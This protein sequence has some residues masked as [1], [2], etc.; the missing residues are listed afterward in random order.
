MESNIL[1]NQYDIY[2]H[3]VSTPGAAVSLQTCVFL[4]NLCNKLQPKTL[5]DTGSGFSSYVF[6][7]WAQPNNATVYSIDDN[8]DW[9]ARSK[10]FCEEQNVYTDNFLLFKDIVIIQKQTAD[11]VLHDLGNRE[12]RKQSLGIIYDLCKRGGTIVF[13]DMHKSDLRK[14]VSDFLIDKKLQHVDHSAETLDSFGRYCWS[15]VIT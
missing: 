9:L 10:Q 8:A 7:R 14:H 3:N 11:L 5:V 1:H 13:D 2:T 6:R 12:T 15:T 4:W